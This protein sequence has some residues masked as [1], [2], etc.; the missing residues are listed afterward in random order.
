[1]SENI[2]VKTSDKFVDR[3]INSNIELEYAAYKAHDCGIFNLLNLIKYTNEEINEF[4]LKN[5]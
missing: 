4:L 1:M 5:E 2:Y 3:F